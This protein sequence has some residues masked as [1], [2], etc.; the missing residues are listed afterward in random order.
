MLAWLDQFNED[1]AAIGQEL[2]LGMDNHGAKQ[3]QAFRAKLQLSNKV[4]AYTP[5]DCT[6]HLSPCDHHVGERLKKMMSVFY[7]AELDTNRQ[8]WCCDDP[9]AAE[10]R[11]MKMATWLT[12]AWSVLRTETAF[13]R[14][15]FVST[16]FLIAKNGSENHLIKVP[17]IDHYTF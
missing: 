16:G 6:D 15:A 10:D 13:I 3:T 1:T 8:A 9:L 4:A 17:G 2:L 5:P 12:G 7:K 14:S 11:R